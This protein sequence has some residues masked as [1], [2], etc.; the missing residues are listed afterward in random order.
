MYGIAFIVSSIVLFFSYTHTQHYLQH[1]NIP[2][3]RLSENRQFYVVKNITKGIYLAFLVLFGFFFIIYPIFNNQYD[4]NTIRMFA[5]L[6]VSNDFIG[7]YR[8]SNLP[9]STRLHHTASIVF[10]LAAWTIDFQ[11]SVVGQM[12]LLYTYF[13]AI[14][15]PVNLYLGLRLC[16]DVAWLRKIAKYIY[17]ISCA[18]NWYVQYQW[19]TV[20]PSVMAYVTLLSVIVF[21]DIVLLRWL[22]NK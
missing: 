18:L 2:F 16:Y 5:S 21:D 8:V 12:L 3:S 6:Y 1:H 19:F 13:S 14:A 9:T 20:E 22:W 11:T 7:L 17:S 4:N 10:L 15:F